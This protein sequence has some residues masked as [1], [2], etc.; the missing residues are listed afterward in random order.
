LSAIATAYWSLP[1]VPAQQS[2]LDEVEN[3][4]RQGKHKSTLQW[5]VSLYA[6]QGLWNHALSLLRGYGDVTA[7]SQLLTIQAE[8]RNPALIDGAVILDVKPTSHSDQDTLEAT[9][10]SPD[11][12]C[13]QRA[14]WWEVI[15]PEGELLKRELIDTVHRDPQPFTTSLDSINI[16]P[17]QELLIRAYFQGS[18]GQDP[19]SGDSLSGYTDQAFRGSLAKGFRSIRLSPDFANWLE[20]ADPQPE[21]CVEE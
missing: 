10:Q 7:F 5:M 21:K 16:D 11:Q 15:T 17:D 9:I 13:D 8:N 4:A 6:K 1:A 19:Y 3:M 18:Y 20:Q 2:G 14:S 12:D